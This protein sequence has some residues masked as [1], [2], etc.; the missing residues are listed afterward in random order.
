MAK[1]SIAIIEKGARHALKSMARHPFV[2]FCALLACG[3]AVLALI[4]FSGN[5]I[6]GFGGNVASVGAPQGADI[7]FSNYQNV[8][9]IWS[10]REKNRLEAGSTEYPEVF[11]SSPAPAPLNPG[12]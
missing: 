1:I 11:K 8:F 6:S 12:M 10:E 2:L 7:D 3:A 9:A 4:I 5:I